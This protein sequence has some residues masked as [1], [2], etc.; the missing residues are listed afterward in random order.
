MAEAAGLAAAPSG[1]WDSVADARIDVLVTIAGDSYMF[2]EPDFAV[3]HQF[4]QVGCKQVL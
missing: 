2:G 1:L 4:R 3:I